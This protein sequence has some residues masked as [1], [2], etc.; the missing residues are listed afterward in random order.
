M[1]QNPNISPENNINTEETKPENGKGAT[2]GAI[3]IVLLLVIGGAYVFSQ[4]QSGPEANQ[5]EELSTQSSSTEIADIEADLE[6]TNLEDLDR[7]LEEIEAEL[8]AELD[9]F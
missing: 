9:N 4:S 1:D 6:N 8:E 2:V 7:E 5:T 3:I